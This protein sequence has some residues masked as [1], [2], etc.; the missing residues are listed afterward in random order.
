MVEPSSGSLQAQI[1]S[2][3]DPRLAALLTDPVARR[4][5]EPFLARTLSAK[6]AADE[7]ECAL[8]TLLYR[9]RV[10]IQV[11]LLKVVEERPRKGRAVK[12]YRSVHDAYFIP[13]SVMPFA[14]LEER[15]Y[16]LAEPSIRAWARSAA[17]RLQARG[18]EGM[19]LYR[20][21]FD[22]MWS[23]SA[24]DVTSVGSLDTRNWDDPQRPPG[25][26]IMMT[27]YLTER[28]AREVQMELAQMVETWRPRTEPGQGRA[29]NLNFFFNPEAR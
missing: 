24:A 21:R 1:H 25:F 10:F 3:T 6:Q 27:V 19:R 11:G 2:V 13:H 28:E 22:Q 8:D 15:L 12:Y 17:G 5:F 23:E 18:V 20:D 16:A 4:Y 26:D 9:I 29:Y 14:T 7:V